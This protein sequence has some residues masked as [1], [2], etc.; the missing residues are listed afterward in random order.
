MVHQRFE[1]VKIPRHVEQTDGKRLGIFE[2]ASD[3][4]DPWEGPANPRYH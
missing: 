1:R 2:T 3:S 4:I